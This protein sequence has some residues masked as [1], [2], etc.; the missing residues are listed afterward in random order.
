MQ[1]SSPRFASWT[2][3]VGAAAIAA[4]ALAFAGQA[5]ATGGGGS[6]EPA[7]PDA[8]G[9]ASVVES[10]FGAYTVE[11]CYEVWS[12]SNPGNPSPVPGSFTYVYTLESDPGSFTNIV[13]F[14]L[15]TPA[16]ASAVSDSGFLAGSGGV[17][18]DG[19]DTSTPGEAVFT[20]LNAG[21][22]G[23]P[24]EGVQGIC[25]GAISAPLV[26]SSPYG[27]G[28]V[29]D[30]LVALLDDFSLQELTACVGPNTLPNPTPCSA[31][32]WKLRALFHFFVKH[33]F[34]DERFDQ[35]TQ[36]AADTST[37]FG[38]PGEVLDGLFTGFFAS[39]T[40]AAERELATLLLNI[41]AGE[42]F[43]GNTKC[44]LFFDTPVDTDGDDVGDTTVGELLVT[45][46]SNILSG[47]P[48]LISEAKQIAL[49]LNLGIGVLDTTMF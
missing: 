22:V 24:C 15:E 19:V 44:R 36:F 27:P 41:A 25:P 28:A 3:V 4:S 46:E 12:A 32:F 39:P 2:R 21:P 38:S 26:V 11:K 30:N 40:E 9:C 34:P 29:D 49:K 1:Y 35:V 13:E 10:Q 5:A 23:G 16:S 7:V 47:D 45:V 18:P 33:H 8:E 17:E 48:A 43:P 6:S 31:F 14:R 37:V 20:F 42:L